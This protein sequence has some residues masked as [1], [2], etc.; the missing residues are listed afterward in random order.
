MLT[1][2]QEALLLR[3]FAAADRRPTELYRRLT[4]AAIDAAFPV[5][6]LV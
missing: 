6:V 3:M 5:H 2:K 1:E 4:E